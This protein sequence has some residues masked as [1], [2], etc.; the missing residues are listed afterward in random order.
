M[1]TSGPIYK[2]FAVEFITCIRANTQIHE[3]QCALINS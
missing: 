1:L 3:F 2:D